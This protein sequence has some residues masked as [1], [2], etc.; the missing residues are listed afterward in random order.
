MEEAISEKPKRRTAAKTEA[1]ADAPKKTVSKA[2]KDPQISPEL[3]HSMIADAAYYRAEKSGSKSA[4][5]DLANWLAAEAE[6]DAMLRKGA[7]SS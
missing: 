3:R 6:I 5:D 1:V 4:S 2:K 7:L